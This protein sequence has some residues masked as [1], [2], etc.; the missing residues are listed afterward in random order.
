MFAT[1]RSPI[2]AVLLAAVLAAPFPA[3]GA[4]A[5]A[6][7]HGQRLLAMQQQNI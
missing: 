5:Q 6:R 1:R 2:V 3:G 7:G 4:L